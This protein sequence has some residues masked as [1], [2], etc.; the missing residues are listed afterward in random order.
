M[1]KLKNRY[2][3]IYIIP[4]LLTIT[5]LVLLFAFFGSRDT[6]LENT[7]SN[8]YYNIVDRNGVLLMNK[9]K[10]EEGNRYSADPQIR[11]STLAI[12]GDPSG[13]IRTSACATKRENEKVSILNGNYIAIHNDDTTTLTIDAALSQKCINTLDGSERGVIL[14]SN[15]QTGEILVCISMP[16]TDPQNMPE[17]IDTNPAYNGTFLNKAFESSYTPGSIFK[18]FTLAAYFESKHA[19]YSYQCIG[20]TAVFDKNKS[21]T[22]TCAGNTAHGE[23]DLFSMTTKSCNC[24]FA[25]MTLLIGERD[26]HQLVKKTGVCSSIEID[27]ITT[28]SGNYDVSN[29]TELAWSGVGQGKITINPATYLQFIN[30]IANNGSAPALHIQ[31]SNKDPQIIEKVSP[32]TANQVR[33]IMRTNGISYSQSHPFPDSLCA[34]TGTAEVDGNKKPTSLFTGFLD[35]PERPYSFLVIVEE[36]GYGITSAAKITSNIL[37]EL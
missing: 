8:Q 3:F 12:V 37:T 22:I 2:L 30:C 25:N 35:D 4:I 19:K 15:Y 34:K 16:Y 6:F 32:T 18:I 9:E 5:G 1:I 33:N 28:K 24:A 20:S 29:D 26:Y 23:V 27:N 7:S 13:N 21:T 36:G 17:D 10:D 14:I 11:K 31:S